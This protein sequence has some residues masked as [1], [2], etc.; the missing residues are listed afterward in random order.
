MPGPP[1][2]PFV[3]NHDHITG[4]HLLTQ[5]ALHRVFLAFVHAGLAGELPD[6]LIHTGCLDDAALLGDVAVEHGQAAVLGE[7]VR[8]WS[9]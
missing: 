2:G 8:P 6:R 7:G 9:G 3:A 4:L 5:D 1:F